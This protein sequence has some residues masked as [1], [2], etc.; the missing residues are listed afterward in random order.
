MWCKNNNINNLHV[1]SE[2]IQYL[3]GILILFHLDIVFHQCS[4]FH[5][6]KKLILEVLAQT[7]AALKSTIPNI[8]TLEGVYFVAWE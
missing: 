3:T 8:H 4:R 7:R 2:T 1:D 6:K 5:L